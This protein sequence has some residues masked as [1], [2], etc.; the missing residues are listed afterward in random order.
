MIKYHQ[1]N[2]GA[3]QAHSEK[4]IKYHQDNPGAGQAQG[5]R[6]KQIYEENSE[7]RENVVVLKKNALKIQ[8]KYKK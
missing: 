7:A 5:K 3:G 2:P 8:K 1:D 6:L 4:M